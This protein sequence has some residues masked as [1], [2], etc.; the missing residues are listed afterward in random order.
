[1]FEGLPGRILEGY[2]AGCDVMIF[3]SEP[4]VKEIKVKLKSYSC[5]LSV[6]SK[7]EYEKYIVKNNVLEGIFSSSF[8]LNHD[9]SK[10]NV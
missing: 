3:I 7:I 1:M 9:H 8:E 2:L 10:Q 5:Q 6:G 4:L